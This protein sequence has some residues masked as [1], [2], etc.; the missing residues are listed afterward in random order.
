MR[1]TVLDR[2]M[3]TLIKEA[4]ANSKGAEGKIFP[5]SHGG[6]GTIRYIA[7]WVMATLI[8]RKKVDAKKLLYYKN[9]RS[10]VD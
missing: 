2:R 6:R 1:E 10:R 3:R 4:E 9:D 7:G 8:H 5:P